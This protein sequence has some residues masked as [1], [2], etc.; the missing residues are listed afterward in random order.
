MNNGAEC[1]SIS[2]WFCHVFYFDFLVAFCAALT[3]YQQCF[4]TFQCHGQQVGW[5]LLS[6]L[7]LVGWCNI[8]GNWKNSNHIIAI[9]D[10]YFS[11]FNVYSGCKFHMGHRILYAVCDQAVHTAS[12]KIGNKFCKHTTFGTALIHN[13]WDVAHQKV[14]LL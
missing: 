14:T 11:W 6:P 12:L 2:P 13:V 5:I 4:G 7:G 8:Y 9:L 10:N 3:P 1:E